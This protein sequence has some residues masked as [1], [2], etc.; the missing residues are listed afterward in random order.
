MRH[1]GTPLQAVIL[2]AIIF[3]SVC[4]GTEALNS[5]HAQTLARSTTGRGVISCFGWGILF[6]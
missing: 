5:F 4:L 1:F 6:L 3:S 2:F